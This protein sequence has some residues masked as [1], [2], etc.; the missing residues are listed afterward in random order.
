MN[1]SYKNNVLLIG[2]F[3]GLSLCANFLFYR[4]TNQYLNNDELYGIWLIILSTMT[5]F[6]IMDFGISNSLRNLLTIAIQKKDRH[7]IN[8]VINTTYVAMI[9]PLIILLY[10][11]LIV[12]QWV[13]WTTLF[14][15]KNSKS[16]VNQMFLITF[17]MFPFV[18]YLNTITYIYHAHFQSYIVN[19]M[20]FLNL[21]ISTLLILAMN[22]IGLHS[23]VSLCVIYFSINVSVSLIFT[24][25]YFK[26]YRKIVK[27]D[28]S[29]YRKDLIKPLLSLGGGFFLLD[30]ASLT[31]LNSGPLLI[32]YFFSPFYSVEFQLTYKLFSIFLTM[33]TVIL[34]PL[35]TLM[36]A[37]LT[38]QQFQDIKRIHKKLMIIICMILISMFFMTW[39][40]NLVI[41][42]WICKSYQIEWIFIFLTATIVMLSIIAFT[43]QTLLNAMN[44][45]YSQAIIYLCGVVVSLGLM[46]I[47][48][49]VFNLGPYYFLLAI[50]S[51]IC[52]PAI[53]LPL[54]FRK[55][56]HKVSIQ[57]TQSKL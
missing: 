28:M 15:I 36:I 26:K 23:V 7:G 8:E 14:H 56:I 17:F 53:V 30:V 9:V 3:T 41:N 12:N 29:G 35:W 45:V 16:D 38:A 31:L 39:M 32:G 55:N 50:N 33:A 20:Q 34:S 5:W 24:V 52:I 10:A 13:D 1:Q 48:L 49:K 44:I 54:I 22:M 57:Y 40:V 43:Y 19:L 37:K 51:G 4:V 25:F 6:Y 47:L 21:F 27:L 11:G 46:F 2:L 42:L 18:F